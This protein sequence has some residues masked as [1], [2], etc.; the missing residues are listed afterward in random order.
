MVSS[1]SET[2]ERDL[3]D[4][5]DEFLVELE[6]RGPSLTGPP[7]PDERLEGAL[8]LF[9]GAIAEAASVGVEPPSYPLAVAKEAI[10]NIEA[11]EDEAERRFLIE[12]A[13]GELAWAAAQ[14]EE[15]VRFTR[16]GPTEEI[17]RRRQAESLRHAALAYVKRH[18]GSYH[19]ARAKVLCRAKVPARRAFRGPARS[20]SRRRSG[21]T[22][23][24]ARSPGRD[25]GGDDP[26]RPPDQLAVVNFASVRCAALYVSQRSRSRSSRS[27]QL[28][29]IG[30]SCL[31]SPETTPQHGQRSCPS[32]RSSSFTSS[33][34]TPTPRRERGWG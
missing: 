26:H 14:I 22:A 18:G 1:A 29:Q 23:R 2:T 10:G 24:R 9:H 34:C 31:A 13:A 21:V 12:E 16:L 4:C 19:A 33:N 20:G 7:T 6:E 32:T 30:S 25:P 17:R 15:F 11:T 5:W 28:R 27:S 3:R 8:G